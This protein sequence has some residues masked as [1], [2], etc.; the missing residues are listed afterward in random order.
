MG[1]TPEDSEVK[2]YNLEDAR[3]WLEEICSNNGIGEYSST[4]E[5]AAATIIHGMLPRID[6]ERR[7]DRGRP[8]FRDGGTLCHGKALALAESCPECG[9]RNLFAPGVTV[10]D[11]AKAM[12]T[13]ETNEPEQHSKVALCK[14]CAGPMHFAPPLLVINGVCE[15]CGTADQR[16]AQSPAKRPMS[17]AMVT[18]PEAALTHRCCV[19]KKLNRG[20]EVATWGDFATC[21]N[22]CGETFLSICSSQGRVLRAMQAELKMLR[23]RET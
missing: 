21:S 7:D 4:T 17:D 18:Y 15:S 10:E 14:H 22:D 1:I 11:V 3:R 13:P 19:C 9:H 16:L 23:G 8:I 2:T 5:K 6:I 12:T 20:D